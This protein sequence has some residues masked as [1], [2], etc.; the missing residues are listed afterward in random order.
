MNF[1]QRSAVVRRLD[2]EAAP[3][4]ASSPQQQPQPSTEVT[5]AITSEGSL[6]DALELE[7]LM[8]NIDASLRVHTRHHFFTWTQ[9]LLQNL[10]KHEVLVCALRDSDSMSFHVDSFATSAS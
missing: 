5:T 4:L 7:S 8:L 1:S 2:D 9:G 3:R 6:P 10:I